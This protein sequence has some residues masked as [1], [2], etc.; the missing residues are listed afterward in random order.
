MKRIAN[1]LLL[2]MLI[3][4]TA[5]SQ[6]FITKTGHIRFYSE[7]PIE[8]IE[9]HN[10]AVNSA[11]NVETGDFVFRVLIKS[12]EFEKALMQEHFNE[13]YMESDK[14]PN[15]M[16]KGR[17]INN[18]GIDFSSDGTYDALVQGD[19]TIHGVT[20]AIEEKGTFIV[21]EGKIQGRSVFNVLLEDYDIKVPGVVRKQ[22]SES[23]EITVNV[24]LEEVKP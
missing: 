23:I 14:Y 7:T 22:I 10:Y 21:K 17:V 15:A 6:N 11:L 4:A 2:I 24:M 3:S 5:Y 12:F 13:N 19:L 9:A 16:F 20:Q 18:D 1:V 8:S